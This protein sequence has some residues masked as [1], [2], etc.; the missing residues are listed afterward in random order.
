MLKALY[1][2]F[3]VPNL[4]MIALTQ[5]LVLYCIIIPNVEL[6]NGMHFMSNLN[7]GLLVLS[8]VL[9]AAAG[10]IIN[11]YFDMRADRINKPDKM[12]IGKKISRRVAIVLHWLFNII[13][14]CL[15]AF[16]AYRM[17]V[18]FN[19]MWKLAILNLIVSVSL[20]YYSTTFKRQV[21]TGNIVISLLTALVIVIVW[22]FEFYAVNSS[23]DTIR[24]MIIVFRSIIM[25]Y[26]I[27]A[28][29]ISLVRELIKDIEDMEGDTKIFCQTFPITYGVE[30]TRNLIGALVIIILLL[31][32][33]AMYIVYIRGVA[34]V[35]W[36]LLAAVELPLVYMLFKIIV[37]KTKEQF[38]SLSVMTK[39]IMF[40]GIL[41]MEVFYL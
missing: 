26:F 41:S 8:T 40:A 37:S 14:V 11:D 18:A 2:L 23:T 21:L 29:I 3:R 13:G 12:S 1:R 32:G 34:L 35:F 28:F 25:P 20:W 17:H 30:K 7:F 22:L 19:I 10:Y 27:F 15:G 24:D 31:L 33:Y 39:I 6:P 5:Y 4:L 9:I 36:Y 38:A 16:V